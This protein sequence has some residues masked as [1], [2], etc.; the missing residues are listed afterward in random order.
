[1]IKLTEV[2]TNSMQYDP[3]AEHRTTSYSLK[4]FYVNP[5]FIISMTDNEKFNSL[6]TARR[7]VDELAPEAKFTKLVV[8]S[9][10]HSTAY[11]DI[12][13]APEQNLTKMSKQ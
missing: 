4:V 7:L 13:G 1:M 2:I 11:Y 8:A 9:G 6:H 12:L 5:K 3:V 10:T